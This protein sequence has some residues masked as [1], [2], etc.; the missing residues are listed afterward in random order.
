MKTIKIPQ[1]VTICDAAGNPVL[2]QAG[3]PVVI[4][5]K[6]FVSGTLLADPKYGKT[7]ND[8]L[9]AVDVKTKLILAEDKLELDDEHWDRLVAVMKEPS[10]PYMPHTVTQIVSFLLAIRDAK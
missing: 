10:N 7:L 6:N 5:F 4:T 8:I 9:S 1:P 2:D 3:N